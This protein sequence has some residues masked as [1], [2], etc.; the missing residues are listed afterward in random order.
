MHRALK[1]VFHTLFHNELEKINMYP[2]SV[3]ENQIKTFPEKQFTVD[4][5]AASKKKPLHFSLPYIGEIS[6]V[7]KT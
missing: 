5:G 4:S 7:T 2:K 1:L 3:I 6:H